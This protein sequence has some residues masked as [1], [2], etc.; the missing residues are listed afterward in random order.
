IVRDPVKRAEA[1]FSLAGV[2]VGETNEPKAT[3]EFLMDMMEQR[4]ALAEAKASKDAAAVNRLAV[5]IEERH[6]GVEKALAEGFSAANGNKEKLG[7]IVA[8]LGEL[9]FY[10]RFLEEVSAIEEES[11][12]AF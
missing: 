7:S 8:K 5:E 12:D 10:R 11:L 6:A 1:L 4:E 3:N 9:R 2:V